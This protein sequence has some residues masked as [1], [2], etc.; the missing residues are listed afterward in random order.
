MGAN[1]GTSV[2]NSIVSFGNAQDKDEFRRA[3]AGATVH[4]MFNFLSVLVLL[5]LEVA[6][7]Y[8]YSLSGAIV[9]SYH[10]HEGNGRENVDLLSA[11][12]KPLTDKIVLLNATVLESIA[13]DKEN[14]TDEDLLV[15]NCD[16]QSCDFLF[17]NS[18]LSD[19]AVGVI[20][21]FMALVILCSCLVFI[22]KLLHSMLH[23]R[24]AFIIRKAVNSDFPK[25]FGFLTGYVAVL[26]GAGVTMLVQSSSVFTSALTPLVGVGV[27]TIE[28]M[29]PLTLGANIGTTITGILAALAS[30][31]NLSHGLQIAMCHLFFNLSGILIWYPIPKLRQVPLFC[32]RSLGN[33]TAKYRWFPILYVTLV[34]FLIPAALFGLS[35]AGWY[36][37]LAVAGPI[38]I[39]FIVII[40]INV[41]QTRRHHW[42]PVCLQSWDYLPYWMHSL[43]PLDGVLTWVGARMKSLCCKT[44]SRKAEGSSILYDSLDPEDPKKKLKGNGSYTTS[45]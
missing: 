17:Y 36:V 23:G 15:T 42:L 9:D 18:G 19:A 7:G 27:I 44:C 43:E 10:L 14:Q 32:A 4:D 28:R 45:L 1:I 11:L 20:V 41:L 39:F 40:V 24:L 21:L 34:F 38:A 12:T 35:L 33:T 37:L 3:F 26:I 2:T 16:D 31:G 13:L 25:P 5:P 22:V 30:K 8:L 6:S 29:Y